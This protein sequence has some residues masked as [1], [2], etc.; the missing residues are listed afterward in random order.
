MAKDAPSLAVGADAAHHSQMRPQCP[1][2][3][4]PPP[5]TNDQWNDRS[6]SFV[7]LKAKMRVHRQAL[8]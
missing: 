4:M 7:A 2:L 5:D 1:P 3:G 8:I 6:Y